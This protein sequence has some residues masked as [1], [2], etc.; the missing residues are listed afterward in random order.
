[1]AHGFLSLED[2]TLFTYKCTSY[3]HPKAERTILWNDPDLAIDWGIDAP[4]VSQKDRT[5]IPFSGP[6][7]APMN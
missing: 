1:M 5:G 7:D 4:I 6:W 3:Y 2:N